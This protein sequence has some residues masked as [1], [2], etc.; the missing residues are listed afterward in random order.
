ME[1]NDSRIAALVGTAYQTGFLGAVTDESDAAL[2]E[3]FGTLA[4][5]HL[6]FRFLQGKNVIAPATDD[7]QTVGDM[8][9][10]WFK[11]SPAYDVLGLADGDA[12]TK[13]KA[14]TKATADAT[15]DDSED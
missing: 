1:E 2:R 11:S 3:L 4:E 7:P 12:V 8:L 9:S 5:S 13:P 6:L 10:Q 14:K 15:A